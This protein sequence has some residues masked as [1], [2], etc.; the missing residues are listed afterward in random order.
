MK[1][2]EPVPTRNEPLEDPGIAEEDNVAA[3][4][5]VYLRTCWEALF[6][7]ET[8]QPTEGYPNVPCFESDGLLTKDFGFSATWWVDVVSRIIQIGPSTFDLCPRRL[9]SFIL[10]TGMQA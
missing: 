10:I 1:A 3:N 7:S 8:L 9:F 5:Q 2:W 6:H 4:H